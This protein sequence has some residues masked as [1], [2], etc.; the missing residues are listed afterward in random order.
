MPAWSN[1]PPK[2]L[3]LI[4]LAELY[5]V[6][7]GGGKAR[8]YWLQ[9]NLRPKVR[10]LRRDRTGARHCPYGPC[11]PVGGV[12]ILAYKHISGFLICSRGNE[13]IYH[14]SQLFLF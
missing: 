12:Y 11:P 2:A 3:L 6:R 7:V 9:R 14:R 5:F 10:S 8:G 4:K 1:R 13:L